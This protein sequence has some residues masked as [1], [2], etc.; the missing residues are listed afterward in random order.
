MARSYFLYLLIGL[1]CTGATCERPVDLDLDIPP[2]RLVI[3]SNFTPGEKVQV[4]V[5]KS[6][7]ILDESPAEYLAT[8][9]VGIYQDGKLIERLD[10][11]IDPAGRTPPYYITPTFEPEPAITYTIKAEAE[12]FEPAMAHSFI[13]APVAIGEFSVSEVMVGPG[14]NSYQETYSYQ[15]FLS[16]E[17]PDDEVNYYHLNF[18]QEVFSYMNSEAGDTIILDKKLEPVQF[19]GLNGTDFIR[20]FLGGGI[21]LKDNPFADGV[22]FSFSLSI[23]PEFEFLGKVFA[24]LRTVSEEYYLFH[25]SISRSQN[26]SDGP[27][28][29]PVAIFN[30]VENGHGVFAGYN[31]AQDSIKLNI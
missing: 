26:Q 28:T 14:P 12:G 22:S 11:V 1:L 31:T 18:Y 4:Q 9:D 6:Q 21:L 5:S 20:S 19:D 25:T 27:F 7:N 24:E 8:A 3:V 30:N 13:P 23:S 2:P 17:D 29:N 16:F 10:L 15:V